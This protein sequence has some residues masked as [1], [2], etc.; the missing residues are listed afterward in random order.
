MVTSTNED[1]LDPGVNH[2]P[3]AYFARL[4]AEDP[5]HW[6]EKHNFWL[7]TRHDDVVHVARRPELFSSA[8][9]RLDQRPPSPPIAEADAPYYEIFKE[10][11]SHD[12]L[13]NDPPVH[14]RMRDAI[15]PSLTPKQAERWR[16]LVR[17]VINELLDGVA[18]K[19]QMDMMREFATPLPL[20]VISEIL[21]IPPA[22]R[23]RLREMAHRHLAFTR[24]TSDRMACGWK[25][26][27]S[28]RST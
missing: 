3:Y 18:S 13:Q 22:D 16:G 10:T 26:G 12:L 5:V 28:S 17:A 2:N 6:D 9:L 21:G 24:A 14:D 27:E 25:A 4:R 23:F 8:Y 1:L 15:H 7:I 11:R 20:F 19:G